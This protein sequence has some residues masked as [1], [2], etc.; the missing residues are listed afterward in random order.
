M[1][2]QKIRAEAKALYEVESC[3]FR[4]I[5]SRLHIPNYATVMQWKARERWEKGKNGSK[6][7]QIALDARWMKAEELGLG[8]VDQLL[9][10]RELMDA[11]WMAIP[12]ASGKLGLY[13][14]PPHLLTSDK[15]GGKYVRFMGSEYPILP[16]H[17]TQ[18]E[19]LRRAMELLGTKVAPSL[20]APEQ[21]ASNITII[22]LPEKE[23]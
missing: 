7:S 13:P 15:A 12:E 22:Q 3:S 9:K 4:E 8:L 6:L 2:S 16:N 19:G 14:K 21:S 5:A 10:A 18:V 11:E 17:K 23:S 20:E 1:Y